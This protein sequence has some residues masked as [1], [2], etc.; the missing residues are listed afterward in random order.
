MPK[1]SAEW[2][3][4]DTD[5]KK[6]LSEAK[7]LGLRGTGIGEKIRKVGDAHMDV[8]QA[9]KGNNVSLTAGYAEV[10]SSLTQ[11]IDLC[12]KTIAKHKKLFTTACAWL[13]EHVKRAAATR[14]AEV[15]AEVKAARDAMSQ[16]C[17]GHFQTLQGAHDAEAFK[18]AWTAYVTE[19]KSHE[20]AFPHLKPFVARAENQKTGDTT[21]YL[22]LAR[23]CQ[24]ATTAVA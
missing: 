24:N 11:L 14:K 8:E 20:L 16:K 22:K 6:V 2:Y 19:L 17:A 5:W 7:N 15:P 10:Q 4:L 21:A 23:E 1:T 12:D 13:D 9:K 18:N 3:K